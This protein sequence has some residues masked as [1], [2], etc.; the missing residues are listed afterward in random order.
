MDVKSYERTT[1]V[2]AAKTATSAALRLVAVLGGFYLAGVLFYWQGLQSP[3][4]S[5]CTFDH[6]F[7]FPFSI[8]WAELKALFSRSYHAVVFENEYHPLVT[9]IYIVNARLGGDTYIGVKILNLT[10][11]VLGAGLV[12]LLGGRLLRGGGW[13]ILAGAIFLLHSVNAEPM[14][15]ADMDADLVMACFAMVAFYARIRSRESES[16][17]WPAAESLA[18]VMALLS[19]ETAVVYPALAFLYGLL[20]PEPGQALNSRSK[21]QYESLLLITAAYALLQF[22]I[23]NAGGAGF[24]EGYDLRVL[25]PM[26]AKNLASGLR[27]LVLPGEYLDLPAAG[28]AAAVAAFAVMAYGASVKSWRWPAFCLGWIA[29]SLL[30][31]LGLLPVEELYEYFK[32]MSNGFS[33]PWMNRRYLFLAMPAFCLLSAS[34]LRSLWERWRYG[35]AAAAALFAAFIMNSARVCPL[36]IFSDSRAAAELH[37]RILCG[38]RPLDYGFSSR[39]FSC[40]VMTS[41]ANISARG[42]EELLGRIRRDLL[43]TFSGPE[44]DSIF[45][46]FGTPGLNRD[47]QRTA[48][49]MAVRDIHS[50]AAFMSELN[51][52]L[53]AG[54]E[55]GAGEP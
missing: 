17:T 46:F 12:C 30:P 11:I 47:R 50:P 18:Y 51:R 24:P 10:F 21:R 16:W 25:L 40:S 39:L 27:I 9:L 36:H 8:G 37:A 42:D 53:A 7:S 1:A 54:A 52:H 13:A 49:Y 31:V 43:K 48:V 35:K 2:P 32:G 33:A 3:W 26:A 45:G 6:L 19:K 23:I 34:F 38:P 22:K 20:L 4:T 28:G 55:S 5:A 15:V 41:L 14:A 44:V 29:V